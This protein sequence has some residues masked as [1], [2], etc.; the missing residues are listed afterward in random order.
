[1][2]CNTF[3]CDAAEGVVTAI[4]GPAIHQIGVPDRPIKPAPGGHSPG[5]GRG[6]DAVPAGA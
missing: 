4:D 3:L 6:L 5:Q 2:G 1:M